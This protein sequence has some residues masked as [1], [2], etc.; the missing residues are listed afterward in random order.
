LN[1]AFDCIT[2]ALLDHGA[3]V[4]KYIGDAILAYLGAPIE[5]SDHA[6]RAIAAAIGVQRAVAERNT[7]AQATGEAFVPLEIGIGIHSG[8]VVVG[9]IGSD[10]K[11]DYTAIGEPVN[12]ANRLQ[13]LAGPGEIVISSDV[14]DRVG[15]VVEATSIGQKR[16]DGI[17]YAIEAFEVRY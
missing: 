10:L 6:Q 16:L 2:S 11:M 8:L 14:R 5:S 13:N 9:N 17:E 12:I 15:D 1:E 7:K 3:T 4:D